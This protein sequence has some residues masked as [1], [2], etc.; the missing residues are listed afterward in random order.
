LVQLDTVRVIAGRAVDAA[1]TEIERRWRASGG[2]TIMDGETV[3]ARSTIFV[4]DALRAMNGVRIVPVGGM[5][6]RI[7]MRG[8][9]RECSPRIYLD[10]VPLG[11]FGG[12]M[13]LDDLVIASDVAAMEVYPRG[14]MVPAQFA[15][16]EE[17]GAVVVWTYQRLGGVMPRDP[18]A[19]AGGR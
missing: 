8:F 19:R 4:T 18:R 5:G 11:H 2:G 6:Q 14:A 12:T 7:L 1:V 13:F 9:G 17:C 10:G 15:G 3:R 16:L